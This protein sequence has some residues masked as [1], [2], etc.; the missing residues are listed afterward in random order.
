MYHVSHQD[1]EGVETMKML[2]DVNAD[3]HRRADLVN[4]GVVDFQKNGMNAARAEIIPRLKKANLQMHAGMFIICLHEACTML[5]PNAIG[6]E[7]A[8]FGDFYHI[9]AGTPGAAER[10]TSAVV[11]GGY[12]LLSAALE[13]EAVD[14]ASCARLSRLFLSLSSE[15]SMVAVTL[16]PSSLAAIHRALG[17]AKVGQET[18]GFGGKR[19]SCES[20]RE[21]LVK[22]RL[23]GS[24]PRPHSEAGDD[25]PGVHRD[26]MSFAI[27]RV[28]EK[29]T[30]KGVGTAATL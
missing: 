15:S 27:M 17:E 7:F 2:Q 30:V 14:T 6:K 3:Q 8:V 16:N 20:I 23:A 28:I 12:A 4:G 19:F 25:L 22:R 24:V 21:W 1:F 9:V 11:A 29:P 5:I 26:Y 10:Y 18:N 13:W